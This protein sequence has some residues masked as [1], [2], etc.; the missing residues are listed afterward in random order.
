MRRRLLDATIATLHDE[1]FRGTTTRKVQ[2]RAG[3]SR[4]AL[5]HHFGSRSE[6]ILAAVEHLAKERMGEVVRLA[7]SPPPRSSRPRW[8][9][10]VLWSTFDGPL[11]AASLELWLAAR[12]DEELLAALVPQERML[13][14]AI[15]DIAGDLFGPD[16]TSSPGF[17]HDLEILLDAMRGAAARGVLRTATGD[18]RLLD[19]WCNLMTGPANERGT[20]P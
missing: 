14:R 13:G 16:S 17:G 1:G 3:V 4:G 2:Q 12:T 8:A 9:I 5:L 7:G 6:L 11:F 15:R 20:G 18:R 10:E 19:S